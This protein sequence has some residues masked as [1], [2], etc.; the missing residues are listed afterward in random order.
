MND[1]CPIC[2][3]KVKEHYRRVVKTWS[4]KGN[5]RENVHEVYTYRCGTTYFPNEAKD[6][7][8][9]GKHCAQIGA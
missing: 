1:H 8:T 6:R 3:A 9:I 2:G 4:K 7:V 5:V